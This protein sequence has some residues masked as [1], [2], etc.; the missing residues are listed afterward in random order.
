MLRAYA[1]ILPDLTLNI[2]SALISAGKHNNP[3]PK[4]IN[5]F[6]LNIELEH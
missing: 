3:P 4:K 2:F 1:D 6:P 5:R